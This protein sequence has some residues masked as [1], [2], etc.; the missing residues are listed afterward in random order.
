MPNGDR[1]GNLYHINCPYGAACNHIHFFWDAIV[2]NYMLMKPTA[3]LYRN[4]FIKN[5]TRLTKEIT[6]SS[7]NLDKT[8]DPMAWSMESL[9]YAKKYGYSTPINDAPNASYYEI[10]RKYGSI[11][12]AMAGHR[13]GYLLDSLLDKAPNIS[14]SFVSEIVV[15]SVNALIL[16]FILFSTFKYKREL[17]NTQF[18][19]L[20]QTTSY[21]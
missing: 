18:E 7:L 13:L 6:E 1:G 8:V 2:L 19:S 4:E 9:E 11:R 10:V 12:V 16:V 17:K 14:H 3:S 5:V 21:V 15:W 20:T